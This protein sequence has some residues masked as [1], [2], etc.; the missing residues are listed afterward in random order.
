[1]RREAAVLNNPARKVRDFAG[2]RSRAPSPGA[3]LTS[4][5]NSTSSDAEAS[6][7]WPR[8]PHRAPTL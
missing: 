1:M 5:K 8:L 4:L 3:H 7:N 6:G 2:S